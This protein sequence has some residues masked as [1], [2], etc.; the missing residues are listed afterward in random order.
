MIRIL[1]AL[2]DTGLMILFPNERGSY[3]LNKP[4]AAKQ[5][6]DKETPK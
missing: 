4:R 5:P 6:C 3:F 1:R 2:L